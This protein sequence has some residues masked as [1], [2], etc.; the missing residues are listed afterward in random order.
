M[1]PQLF[2]SEQE[3]APPEQ[4]HSYPA[5]PD[6]ASYGAQEDFS[7]PSGTGEQSG[8]MFTIIALCMVVA[9]GAGGLWF[10]RVIAKGRTLEEMDSP[11]IDYPLEKER[12]DAAQG[13]EQVLRDLSTSAEFPTVPLGQVQMNPF[14][15][16]VESARSAEQNAS[17]A[18]PAEMARRE[19]ERRRKEIE[20]RFS[21]L[22]L[23][24][25]MNGS[26]PMAQISGELVRAGD[27]IDE[28][29]TVTAITGRSVTLEA[30][31]ETYTLNM[32]T[33]K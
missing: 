19:E 6:S 17:T 5:A 10:M 1:N 24:S 22:K 16:K 7:T 26:V 8:R 2:P 3:S 21:M 28:I 4:N 14:T 18:D 27:T 11:S 33:D 31:G 20:E 13:H 9:I 32:N 29:F 12:T 23:N 30:E 15:L 25:V